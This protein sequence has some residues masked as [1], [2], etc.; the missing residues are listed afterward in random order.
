MSFRISP[1]RRHWAL[2]LTSAIVGLI[3]ARGAIE[4]WAANA[5]DVTP[6]E[7]RMGWAGPEA[8]AQAAPLLAEMPRFDIEGAVRDNAR[9][10]VRLWHFARQ[11]N[12]GEHLPTFRQEIGDCVSMGA[13]NAIN[14]LACVQIARD[15]SDQEYHPCYQ[16]YIYGVSRVLIGKRQMSGS[17]GSVGAWAAAGVQKYGVLKSDFAGV[18]SYSGSVA[19]QWGNAGPPAKFVEEAKKALVKTTAPVKSADD[20]RDA[21]CNGYPCSIASSWGGLM[22]PPATDGR[23]VNRRAGSWSHQMCIIG[24][25]G[26]TGSEPYFYILNSWG[27]NAHGTPPDDAPPGG[28]WVRRADV[29]WIAQQGDS[30]AFSGF[31]G[32]PAQELDFRIIGETPNELR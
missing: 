12:H 15:R 27:P 17:D 14:Y 23:L 29:D 25:D 21:I 16:P 8:V 30:F 2:L 20:V 1:R 11:V 9:A 18:P 26:E 28:F 32:F 31:D 6:L 5:L 19:R 22:N 4:F 10:N 7:A 3:V 13:S 24:Y